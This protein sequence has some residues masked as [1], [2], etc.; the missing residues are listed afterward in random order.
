MTIISFRPGPTRF[1]AAGLAPF[2]T[3]EPMTQLAADP[4]PESRAPDERRRVGPTPLRSR[5][6]LAAAARKGGGTWLVG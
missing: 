4:T 3:V 6:S 1:V 2:E 5:A